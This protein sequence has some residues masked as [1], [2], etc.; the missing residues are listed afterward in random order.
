MGNVIEQKVS[1]TTH[2]IIGT[3]FQELVKE[4]ST[5]TSAIL[6]VACI[7]IVGYIIYHCMIMMFF[8]KPETTQKVIFAYF[9][10]LLVRVLNTI[11]AI[12]H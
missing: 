12:K 10:L 4:L 2:S 7:G 3:V 8:S 6:A 11:I 5:L 1:E 9:M